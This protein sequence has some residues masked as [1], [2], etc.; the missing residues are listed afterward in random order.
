ML[1]KKNKNCL[2]LIGGFV[3]VDRLYIASYGF[4]GQGV[5]L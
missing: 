5:I 4:E 1:E 2:L 3:E